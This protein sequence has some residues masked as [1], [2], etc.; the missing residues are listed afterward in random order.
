MLGLCRLPLRDSRPKTKIGLKFPIKNRREESMMD[1][2][3]WLWLSRR[4]QQ[5]MKMM[6]LTNWLEIGSEMRRKRNKMRADFVYQTY[7]IIKL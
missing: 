4:Y 2:S 1:L 3:I 6:E 7:I 5:R